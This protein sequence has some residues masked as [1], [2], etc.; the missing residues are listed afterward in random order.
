MA[1]SFNDGTGKMVQQF[2]VQAAATQ[3]DPDLISSTP[4]VAHKSL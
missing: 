4:L 1:R 2:R 3:E